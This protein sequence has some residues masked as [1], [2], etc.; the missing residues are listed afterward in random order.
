MTERV[1]SV[2]MEEVGTDRREDVV[3]E[4]EEQAV[5][6]EEDMDVKVAG[7]PERVVGAEEE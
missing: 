6:L 3:V 4:V 2:P 1:G 7:V 5:L